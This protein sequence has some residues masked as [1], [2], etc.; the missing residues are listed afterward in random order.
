MPRFPAAALR[1]GIGHRVQG[2][3]PAATP[4]TLQPTPS[5]DARASIF[6]RSVRIEVRLT[7]PEGWHVNSHRPLQDYL[8]PTELRLEPGVT[9]RLLRV[10]Y[11][12]GETVTLPFDPEPLSVYQGTVTLIAEVEA[13][14]GLGAGSVTIPLLVSYQACSD[15][16]CLPPAEARVEVTA[17]ATS[18]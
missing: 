9:Y 12:E 3:R 5:I 10:E 4:Y 17:S 11:P 2:V 1:E 6:G 16:E 15:R 13:P 14:P 18:A 7:I 8:R